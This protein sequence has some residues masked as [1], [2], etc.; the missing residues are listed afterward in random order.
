[1]HKWYQDTDCPGPWLSYRFDDLA[2]EINALLK[3]RT[4]AGVYRCNVD[5]LNIRECPSLDSAIVGQY[6][7]NE[8]VALDNFRIVHEGYVWGRYTGLASG[9]KR[10]VAIGPYTGKDE[11]T[12]YLIAV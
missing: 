6:H 12:D 9:N 10:Y 5:T 3:A 8:T 1:M 11:P 4:Y 2:S 7:Y